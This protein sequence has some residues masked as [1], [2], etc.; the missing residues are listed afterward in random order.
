[1]MTNLN[2]WTAVAIVILI[3]YLIGIP[4][5]RG[6]ERK[7]TMTPVWYHHRLWILWFAFWLVC[8]TADAVSGAWRFTI[9]YLDDIGYQW[10]TW[11]ERR[12]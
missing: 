7:T 1:M 8:Q 4:I 11:A 3:V 2:P 6:C 9:R 10:A 12:G 5:A